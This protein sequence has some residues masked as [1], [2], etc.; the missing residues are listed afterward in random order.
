MSRIEDTEVDNTFAF[1]VTN[2][3]L[4]AVMHVLLNLAVINDLVIKVLLEQ[5]K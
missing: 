4:S 1:Y 2:S 5:H 3:C